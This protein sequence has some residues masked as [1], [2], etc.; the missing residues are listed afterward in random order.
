MLSLTKEYFVQTDILG[1]KAQYLLQTVNL[2][3]KV[4]PRDLITRALKSWEYKECKGEGQ[5]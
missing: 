1:S 5:I 2:N 4:K 3:L